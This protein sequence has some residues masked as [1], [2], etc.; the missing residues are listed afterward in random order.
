MTTY[1]LKTVRQLNKHCQNGQYSFEYLVI[2]VV[3]LTVFL[4]S[5]SSSDGTG[6]GVYSLAVNTI[7]TL[8][9]SFTYVISLPL[10]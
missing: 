10:I 9:S 6:E 3:I 4:V 5:Y 8:W 2:S 1:N 7:R